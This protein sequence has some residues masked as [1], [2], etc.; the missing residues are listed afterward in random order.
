M[1]GGSIS[2]VDTEIFSLRVAAPL[3]S[4]RI[5]GSNPTILNAY[6]DMLETTRADNDLLS[7]PCQLF[8][9]DETGLPLTPKPPKLVCKK[10]ST[11]I[12]AERSSL[13][14]SCDALLV[15]WKEC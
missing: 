1:A 6:F 10:G 7:K 3:S 13:E 12:N 9:M 8:N 5:E 15:I 4:A 11:N 2:A 14:H